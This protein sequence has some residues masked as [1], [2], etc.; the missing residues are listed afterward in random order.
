VSLT[1]PVQRH[2]PDRVRM[3]TRGG[4]EITLL[5]LATHRS[6]LPRLPSNL[7]PEDRTD[8][9]ASYTVDRMFDFLSGYELDREIGSRFEY[10]NLGVG[11]LGHALARA[12]GVDYATLVRERILTP[13]GM[14]S[15]GIDLTEEMR[16]WMAR[17]HDDRG[18]PVTLWESGVLAGAGGLQSD[19]LDM[20]RFLDANVGE[21]ESE[22][23]VA[24]RDAHV[25][26]PAAGTT[27]RAAAQSASPLVGLNWLIVP[28]G[29]STIVWHNGG[30]GGFRSFIAFDP[31]REAGVVVLTNSQLSVDDIGLHLLEPTIPLTAVT[32]GW[33]PGW[34]VALLVLA[35][36][37]GVIALELVG[38]PRS[39]GRS[40][41]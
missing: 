18:R 8:P 32:P 30:T 39:R 41:D 10:S 19:I 24:M 31:G 23:E 37:V 38:P 29:D 33:W 7:D 20:L 25:A 12:A 14:R 17:G 34:G 6:G 40:K 22:L 27:E 26:R 36:V 13:L 21:P 9:Y 3:P 4:R 11:L 15:T 16:G 2:L 35:F 28:A 5:D 1:D